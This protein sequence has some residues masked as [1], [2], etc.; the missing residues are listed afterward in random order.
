MNSTVPRTKELRQD[1]LI[2][3]GFRDSDIDAFYEAI[4]ESFVALNRYMTWCHDSYSRDET[5]TWV[6]SREKEWAEGHDFSFVIEDGQSGLVLGAIGLNSIN[7]MNKFANL[8][9]WIRTS[10]TGRGVASRA[11]RMV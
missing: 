5:V 8:G 6:S 11:T 1:E 10:C 3:R 2:L 4:Q 7:Y 9:Y